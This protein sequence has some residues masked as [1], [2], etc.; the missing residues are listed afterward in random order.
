[1]D[2]PMNILGRLEAIQE[3]VVPFARRYSKELWVLA[4]VLLAVHDVFGAHGVLAMRRSQKEA[5]QI[6]QEIQRLD[7]ENR[8]LQDRVKAL[9]TDPTAIERIARDEMGLARPGELIFK[10]PPKPSDSAAS[11]SKGSTP[12][13]K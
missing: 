5:A 11:A 2:L 1:M 12:S 6:R 4:F 10:L 7:D 3:R 13:S 8:R 9:K